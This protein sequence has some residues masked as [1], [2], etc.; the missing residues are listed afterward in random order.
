M[1]KSILPTVLPFAIFVLVMALRLRTMNRARPLRSGAL[2]V[3]PAILVAVGIA[4]LVANPPGLVGGLACALA[5][6][7]GGA[8]GWQR[9][10]MIHI[11]RAPGTG[12]LMQRMSPAAMLLL[13]GII[14][15]RALVRQYSGVSPDAA[16]HLSGHALLVAD[17]L[18]CFAIGLVSGTRIEMALR[19]RRID[20]GEEQAETLPAGPA[21]R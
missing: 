4:S 5:V 15:V 18:L 14:F 21:A 3:V 17:A 1:D 2:W 12:R 16:G 20:A 8:V 9:G 7:V 11:W 6:L 10:R 19:I 13:L